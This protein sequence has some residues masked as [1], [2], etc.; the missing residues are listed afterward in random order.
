MEYGTP[1]GT[2]SVDV[3]SP[4]RARKA[5]VGYGAE[6]GLPYNPV[7]DA[8]SAGVMPEAERNEL[9]QQL[10]NASGTAVTGL[11]DGLGWLGARTREVV[12]GRSYGS[13]PSGNTVLEDYG[14]RVP[15]TAWGGY[16]RPLANFAAESLLDPL[17]YTGVGPLGG[18]LSKAG[19][20]AKAA[21]F[22]DD[23]ARA[24]SRGMVDDIISGAST[25]DDLGKV[26]KRTAGFYAKEYGK[27]VS[28]LTDED[29]YARPLYGWRESRRS[30]TLG[31]LLERQKD[32]GQEHYDE[33]SQSLKDWLYRNGGWSPNPTRDLAKLSGQ[34]LSNDLSFMG[35]GL[36]LPFGGVMSRELDNL[37]N[38]V[39]WSGPG[40]WTTSWFD[41]SLHGASNANDQ[42]ATKI[43][44]RG[45]QM[46]DVMARTKSRQLVSLLPKFK[47]AATDIRMGNAIR[48]VIEE[49]GPTLKNQ[50]LADYNTVFKHLQ[51]YRAGTATGEGH[52]IGQFIDEWK[53]SAKD[54][55]ERSRQAGIGGSELNDT[56]GHGYFP[57]VLDDMTFGGAN[58]GTGGRTFSVSTGDQM[59]RDN[60]F[61]VPG[62]TQTIRELSLDHNVA[63]A[64]RLSYTDDLAGDYILKKMREKEQALDAAGVLPRDSTGTPVSYTKAQAVSLARKLREVTPE[65]LE[66]KLPMFGMH[67][68]EALTKYIS[69]RERSIKR[70]G[71][72]TDMLASSAIPKGSIHVPGGGA[73][74]INDA[75]NALDLKSIDRRGLMLPP[76]VADLEGAKL[77]ITNRLKE[78]GVKHGIP[79][80]QNIDVDDLAKISIDTRLLNRLNKVADFY[81]VPEAQSQLFK[82][83]DAITSLWKASILSWPARFVRDWYSGTFSNVIEVGSVND[84]WAG[85]SGA[86]S[87]L[88]GQER[89]LQRFLDRVPKYRGLSAADKMSAYLDDL[90]GAGIS[91]GRQLDDVGQTVAARQSSQGVRGELMAGAAPETTFL[92]Q[93]GDFLAGKHFTGEAVSPSRLAS[94][95]LRNLG[96]WWRAASWDSSNPS[97]LSA[98]SLGGMRRSMWDAAHG[99]KSQEIINPMLRWSARLGD[100]TDK[101]NRIAGFN[102]LI[103]QGVS[104]KEAAK[105]VMAAHVDYNSLTKV[106]RGF[107]R[108]V[109]PFWAYESRIAKWALTKM[110][111]KPGGLYTKLGMNLPRDLAENDVKSD[112]VPSRIADKY[113]LSLEPMRKIPGIG[114]LVDMVAPQT[115]NVSSWLSDIDLPGIDQINKIKIKTDAET[116]RVDAVATLLA[117]IGQVAEG[118]HPLVKS[119]YEVSTGRDAY[120]GLKKNYARNTGPVL[121]ER[122]GVVDPSDYK[123]MSRLGYADQ[124]LQFLLPFY[125]RSAQAAR[126]FTDPRIA[127]QEARALQTLMN[128]TSGVKI[129]NIDDTEKQRDAL[130]K[131]KELLDDH[132]AVRSYESTYIPEELMPFVDERTQRMYQLDRQLRKERRNMSKLKPE[133][134][135]P[136]NY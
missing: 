81:Q 118:A 130:D 135:N 107:I 68:A 36:N 90:A 19:K 23:S 78:I 13:N 103:L 97:T 89:Q 128:A 119:G 105:R 74:A 122:A 17:T 16:G 84:L 9:L 58:S 80:F 27:D 77:N 7:D 41:K 93:A 111:E 83:M 53:H 46:A 123:T 79:E 102:G 12:S 121:L 136:M 26:G 4:A 109:L 34:K 132:P 48:N 104:V 96:N 18:G 106:E 52:Q 98:L 69:G 85:Y 99:R 21:G 3:K 64:G 43:L 42:V 101:I 65:A 28:R 37:G 38:Y 50:D 55:L 94:S 20:A 112:Y 125:S 5:P 14:L 57:R 11:L 117:S 70:A 108:T 124:A 40:S 10:S 51:D 8:V 67:P 1:Y 131:I 22:L 100:T 56:F 75:I 33:A 60:A 45:D 134:Y 30:Q 88:Q 92:W 49:V 63:G 29:L 66:K 59:A 126:K 82:T 44:S 129:E 35:L 86:K 47:D 31:D 32:W 115:G 2:P 116:G 87:L 91:R 76:G 62:G 71:T 39:R 133:V 120:T 6:Y 73:T 25:A 54:Y 24:M 127:T 113:G 15:E 61:H 72:L 95:E 114:S 110:A